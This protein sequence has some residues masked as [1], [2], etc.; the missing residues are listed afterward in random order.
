MPES[1]YCQ[2]NPQSSA[3]YQCV[4]DHF[5]SFEL[6][7]AEKFSRQYGFSRPYVKSVIYRYLDCGVLKNGFA[8]VRCGD[9]GHEYLL[10]FSC[11]RRYFCPSCHQK[12]VVEFGEW[13]CRK[14]VKA[15]PHRHVVLSIPKILRRYFLFDRKLLSE[16]SRCGWDALKT[17]FTTGSRNKKAVPGAVFAIQTFGDFLGFHPHLHILVSDG[18]FH[19]NGMFTVLPDI[20]TKALERIFRHRILKMLLAKGKITQDMIM[21]LDKWKHTRFNAL[22]GPR[23]LPNQDRSMENLARY[24]IRA[25]FSQERMTYHKDAGQV[26]YRS[27][28]SSR[29]KVF[30]AKEWL[31]AMCSHVPNKGEQMARYYGYYS[32]VARG[33]RKKL[34]T[35]EKIPCIQEPD[36]AGNIMRRNWARMI[37]RIYEVDPL[38]C[39][40]CSGEMRVIAFIENPHVIKKILKH[41]NLWD[42]NRKPHPTANGPPKDLTIVYDEQKGP[43]TDDY[44]RDPDYPAEAYF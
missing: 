32:N 9:C 35:D 21:L 31:A 19:E 14:V 12:R 15:V 25:S 7:Y 17:L 26:E 29:V 4:E 2:R 39:L 30:D 22:A 10:A 36:P 42:V 27:K 43:S 11:K 6:M 41:L 44:I 33:K 5:E 34:K 1:V 18:C 40:K 38:T 37:Q 8:R 23:I 24:I 20:D 3:Y 13:L 16:L 28:D